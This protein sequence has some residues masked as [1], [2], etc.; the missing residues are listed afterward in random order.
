MGECAFGCRWTDIDEGVG[1]ADSGL[2]TRR[3]ED[4][5]TSWEINHSTA[6]TFQHT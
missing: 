2:Q 3:L 6:F 4:K 5:F 1:F